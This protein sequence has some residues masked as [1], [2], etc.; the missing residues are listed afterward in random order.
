MVDFVP[1][2]RRWYDRRN[3]RDAGEKGRLPKSN[4]RGHGN[5]APFLCPFLCPFYRPIFTDRTD[6]G[7]GRKDGSRYVPLSETKEPFPCLPLSLEKSHPPC[8]CL[9]T[10]L[11]IALFYVQGLQTKFHCMRFQAIP[12]SVRC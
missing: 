9:S 10:L 12:L 7:K 11:T 5:M 4:L 6:K 1:T 3:P 2:T 8:L